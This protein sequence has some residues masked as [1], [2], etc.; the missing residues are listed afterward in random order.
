MKNLIY[1]PVLN[2]E[3][4]YLDKTARM[5]QEEEDTTSSIYL[6]IIPSMKAE[7]FKFLML[8]YETMFCQ[9]IIQLCAVYVGSW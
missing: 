2:Y 1:L 3:F 5:F 4:F 6:F 9:K 7:C 8:Q